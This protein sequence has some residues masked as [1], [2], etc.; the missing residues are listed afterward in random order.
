MIAKPL[1]Q[2]VEKIS[3]KTPIG[4]VLR[5]AEW[6]DVPL[7]LRE[8][9]FLSS[10]IESAR[11]LQTAHDKIK[12]SISL[13]RE[14]VKNGDALIDRSSFIADLRKIAK[15][16][17]IPV[18]PAQRGGL[19]DI[20][21]RKR[22]G[23]IFD[24][25]TQQ[26]Q[27]YARWK[28]EQDPD[29]LDAFPAQELIRLESRDVPRLWIN[30]WLAVGGTLHNGRMIALKND[31]VWRAISRF[32]TPWPP[33]DFNSGMGLEDI[34]RDQAEALG[35]IA[36]GDT[37][38]PAQ[39]DFN[40]ELQASVRGLSPAI[41]RQLTAFFGDQVQITDG[42]AKWTGTARPATAETLPDIRARLARATDP[43]E[44]RILQARIAELEGLPS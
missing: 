1:E 42:T 2:A 13:Q 43:A 6:A 17:G 27:E 15:S 12:K 21:S 32:G 9:A 7:A 22:L 3:A 28:A 41:Q 23:M 39:E 26:A 20:T 16:E 29:V 44:I 33:Y 24:I 25:Q 40:T 31:P 18:D 11:F 4:S 14:R 34:D 37:T 30:R 19:Q 8:R 36:P 35:L 10:G 38:E 5:S